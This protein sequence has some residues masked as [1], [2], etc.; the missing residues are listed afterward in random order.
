MR[1]KRHQQ[2][3]K[4][5]LCFEI[6]QGARDRILEEL[7]KNPEGIQLGEHFISS[8]KIHSFLRGQKTPP[9]S[10]HG[11]LIRYAYDLH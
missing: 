10:I 4:E 7:E 9:A 11:E 1:P 5:L 6:P 3:Q 8:T 2:S